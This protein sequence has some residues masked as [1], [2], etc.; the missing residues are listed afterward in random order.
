MDEYLEDL[1]VPRKEVGG[2]RTLVLGKRA[3][4]FCFQAEL[5]GKD[6]IWPFLTTGKP[7]FYGTEPELI[8][9]WQETERKSVDGSHFELPYA[10]DSFPLIL[11]YKAF[12]ENVSEQEFDKFLREIVRVLAFG[13]TALIYPSWT[14]SWSVAGLVRAVG[15]VNSIYDDKTLPVTIEVKPIKKEQQHSI[16]EHGGMVI[17][18]KN[19][20]HE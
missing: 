17:I 3:F 13:G 11:S 8:E 2:I 15:A 20:A 6:N 12:D 5:V 7:E 4:T 9:A 10:E 18:R 14:D 19:W 1:G 16:A